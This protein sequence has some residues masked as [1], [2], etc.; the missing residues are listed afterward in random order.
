M[1]LILEEYVRLNDLFDP[2]R[3]A[4]TLVKLALWSLFLIVAWQTLA[5]LLSQLSGAQLLLAVLAFVA[6]SP[7]AYLIR[8]ARGHKAE[9]GGGRR[10][11]ERTPL[12]PQNGGD[13]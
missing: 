4:E 3:G 7:I 5:G 13:E 9:R 6:M 11:A 1:I 12:L 2:R 8:K 10:G